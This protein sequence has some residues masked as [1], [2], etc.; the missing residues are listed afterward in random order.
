METTSATTG[1]E[2]GNGT[3]TDQE[4]KDRGELATRI[5]EAIGKRASASTIFGA[6]VE[7]DGV[8]VIPVA[9]VAWGFGG[10]FGDNASRALKAMQ[11]ESAT[12]AATSPVGRPARRRGG[13]GGGGGARLQP[14]GFIVVR[15]GDATF[16]P[17]YRVPPF[18]AAVLGAVIGLSLARRMSNR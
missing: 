1:W 10:G 16:R 13:A 17:I 7:R 15:D 9:S 6:A 2:T 3:T 4:M 8:T 11:F 18:A 12:N 14:I 5:A